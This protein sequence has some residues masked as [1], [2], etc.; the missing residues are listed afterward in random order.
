MTITI[1]GTEDAPVIAGTHTGTVTED[2]RLSA[3]G[4]L[5][6]TDADSADNTQTYSVLAGGSRD[7][8]SFSIDASSGTWTYDLNNAAVQGMG[9]GDS[10]TRSFTVRATG[11]DGETVDQVVTITINGTEDAPVIAGTHTGT[12]KEDTT[13]STS[14]TL[15]ATDADSAD[16]TQTY[17]VLAGGSSDLGSFGLDTSSGTWTYTLNNAAVQGLGGGDSVT[18]SFTVRATGADGETVDQV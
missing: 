7:L 15:T 5:T 4:T 16:N 8:G 9:G 13:L 10:V 14:G 11:A 1:N 18:R 2:T 17:S 12:V 6:A 3:S